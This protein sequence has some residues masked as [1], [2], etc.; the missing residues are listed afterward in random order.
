[1]D[2]RNQAQQEIDA[3]NQEMRQSR[4]NRSEMEGLKTP[5]DSLVPPPEV[6]PIPATGDSR[7][8]VAESSFKT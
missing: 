5:G 4:R 6:R 3:A 1:M 8:R 7:K 2:A